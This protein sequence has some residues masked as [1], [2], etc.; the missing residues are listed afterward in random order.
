VNLRM[1]SL[2]PGGELTF[3]EEHGFQ[4]QYS[5]VV[6][7]NQPDGTAPIIFPEDIATGEGVAPNPNCG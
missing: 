6:Q 4:A 5:F 7:Q 3:P 2:V 1:E